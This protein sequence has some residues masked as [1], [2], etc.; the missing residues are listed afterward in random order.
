M[1]PNI[2]CCVLLFVSYTYP[3]L[4]CFFVVEIIIYSKWSYFATLC[5]CSVW[6]CPKLLYVSVFQWHICLDMATNVRFCLSETQVD[7]FLT[8]YQEFLD[9]RLAKMVREVVLRS[10]S[11]MELPL[12]G[13]LRS[14]SRFFFRL[15]PGA[16]AQCCGSDQFLT[17]SGSDFSDRI[18]IRILILVESANFVETYRLARWL[19]F[20]CSSSNN[21]KSNKCSKCIYVLIRI[22]KTA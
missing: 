14:R 4:I 6:M 9:G 21:L 2:F 8:L 10:R 18:R 19:T 1:I 16:G 5:K 22:K 12:L 7:T 11:R 20:F 15:E 17:G 13:R 3:L